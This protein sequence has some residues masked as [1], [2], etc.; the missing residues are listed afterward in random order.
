VRSGSVSARLVESE[1][2]KPYLVSPPVQGKSQPLRALCFSLSRCRRNQV[3][4]LMLLS[5][6]TREPHMPT[7]CES[8]RSLPDLSSSAAVVF[9]A[10]DLFGAG[11]GRRTRSDKEPSQGTKG[12]TPL[13]LTASPVSLFILGHRPPVR[14]FG[15]LAT[16]CPI[17][18][19]SCH[20]TPLLR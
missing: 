16:R 8:C 2:C 1:G 9:S 18:Q 4:L 6:V 3:P 10:S 11:E 17:R 13:S 7:P 14:R 19:C 5:L 20:R 12:L 15:P